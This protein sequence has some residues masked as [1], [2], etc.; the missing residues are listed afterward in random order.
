LVG[1]G[2]NLNAAPN[3]AFFYVLTGAHAIHLIGGLIAMLYAGAITSLFSKSLE[4]HC[5]AVDITAWYWHAMG[6]LWLYI[7]LVIAVSTRL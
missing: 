5:I 2:L 1:Y 3:S 6:F 7:L 4:T